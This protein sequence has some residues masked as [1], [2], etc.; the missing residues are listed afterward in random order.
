MLNTPTTFH[1]QCITKTLQKR[2]ET[3]RFTPVMWDAVETV[4]KAHSQKARV[5]SKNK[6]QRGQV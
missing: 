6:S 5:S 4:F 1:S 2:T 3:A